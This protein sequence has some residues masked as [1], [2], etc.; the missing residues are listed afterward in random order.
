MF[1]KSFINKSEN[2]YI[3]LKTWSHMANPATLREVAELAG[4]SIGTASQALNNRPNVSPETRAKVL[5]AARSLGYIFKDSAVAP[6][7]SPLSVLGMLTKHDYGEAVAPNPFYSH[8][9]MGV[10]NECR[11]RG[12]NLMYA[13]IEVDRKNRPVEYPVM[14]REQSVDGLLLIGTLLEET[15]DQIKKHF[16][17]I[18]IVLIDSYAP[19]MNFDSIVTDNVNGAAAMVGYIADQGHRAIGLIGCHEES[20]PSIQ[21]RRLGY[22]QALKARDISGTWIEAGDLTREEGYRAT[23]QLLRR[24]PEVTAIFV[25]NDETAIGVY[26][27]IRDLGLRIP[28]DIS[29]AG[30]DNI[31][32]ARDISPALTTVHVQ[33]AFMGMLGVRCLN[34]RA[35]Y[36]DQPK[37]TTLVSTQM[38]IRESVGVP[39]AS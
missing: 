5:D 29:V 21:E 23:Q 39:Q 38:V 32:L 10:E 11:K 14:I 2:F 9:Q 37:T 6:C 20:S 22:L 12:I 34:E 24:A 27:G 28:Q 8:I 35:I 17:Q 13:N 26:Q 31:D 1:N 25:C 15:I 16:G 19:G 3:L 33:K 30:F 4:V 18:P 36:P 7:D